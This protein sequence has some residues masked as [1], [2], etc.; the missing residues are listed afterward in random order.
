MANRASHYSATSRSNTM[1]QQNVSQQMSTTSCLN[2]CHTA[3]SASHP[4]LLESSTSLVVNTWVTGSSTGPDGRF[5]G[6]VDAD[7][8][9]RAWEHARRRAE[10]GAIV[11]GYVYL[12]EKW[13]DLTASG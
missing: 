4:V 11:L 8:A 1:M 10:D 13:R 7:M 2:A 9:R 5:G 12:L 3:Y 6:T